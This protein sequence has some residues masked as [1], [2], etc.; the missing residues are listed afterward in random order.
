MAEHS[1]EELERQYE[2]AKGRAMQAKESEMKA[3][4]RL[5]DAQLASTGLVGHKVSYTVGRWMNTDDQRFFVVTG[6]RGFGHMTGP[7]IK[8]DGHIG[9]RGTSAHISE[10]TDHGIYEEPK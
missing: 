4:G 5:R 3:L 2:A 9:G 1:I 8:K 10:L 7:L 6:M